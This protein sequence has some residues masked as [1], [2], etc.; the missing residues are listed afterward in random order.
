MR[1]RRVLCGVGKVGPLTLEGQGDL[2]K[3]EGKGEETDITSS[4]IAAC[5]PSVFTPGWQVADPTD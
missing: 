5:A 2:D 4:N 3:V 1:A